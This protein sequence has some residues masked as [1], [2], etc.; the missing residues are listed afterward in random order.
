[1]R[2]AWWVWVG[3]LGGGVRCEVSGLGFGL[4]ALGF[5]RWALGFGP[6]ALGIG[7]WGVLVGVGGYGFPR[8]VSTKIL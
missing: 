6:W 4:W 8:V 2:G 7:H 1:M 5:G 3:L